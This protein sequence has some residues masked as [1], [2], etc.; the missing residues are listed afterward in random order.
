[1]KLTQAEFQDFTDAMISLLED[2][3]FLCNYNEAQE[4]AGIIKEVNDH[5]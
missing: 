2:R 5:L 4:S 1:M 3:F